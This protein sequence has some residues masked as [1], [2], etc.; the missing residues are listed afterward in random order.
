MSS[1]RVTYT[2]FVSTL[3]AYG[4]EHVIQAAALIKVPEAIAFE[5]AAARTMR[6]LTSPYLMR[7]IYDFK[8]NEGFLRKAA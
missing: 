3:G 2:G 6:G 8:C 4:T 7:R 5:T 1:D